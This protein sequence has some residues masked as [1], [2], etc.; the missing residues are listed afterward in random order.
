MKIITLFA[1]ARKTWTEDKFK[2]TNIE[3]GLCP[4]CASINTFQYLYTCSQWRW[5]IEIPENW[6]FGV[7]D[8]VKLLPVRVP[9]PVYCCTACAL[10]IKIFPSFCL[11]GTTLTIQALAFIGFVYETTE[12]TWRDLPEML[13]DANNKIAHS[14]LYKAVH[15]A[16][17][18]MATEQQIQKLHLKHLPSNNPDQSNPPSLWPPPKSIFTYTVARE[19][20]IRLFLTNLL[21]GKLKRL[22][23]QAYFYRYINFL[24]RIFAAWNKAINNIY[25]KLKTSP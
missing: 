2:N 4:A 8:Q 11:R 24:N 7:W 23:F 3:I 22:N 9:L 13:C 12:L 15:S 25:S 21:P 18:L 6:T 17:K 1:P 5:D 20:G 19:K 14:T 10:Q 16:G